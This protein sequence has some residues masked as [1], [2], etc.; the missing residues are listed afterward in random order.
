M[1]HKHCI[2]RKEQRRKEVAYENTGYGSCDR[3]HQRQQKKYA[4]DG[5]RI[6]RGVSFCIAFIIRFIQETRKKDRVIFSDF[7]EPEFDTGA[8]GR[9]FDKW[10]GSYV[11]IGYKVEREKFC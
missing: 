1:R 10:D 4:D 9:Y 8:A 7:N 2:V 5:K 6:Q 11:G 3:E